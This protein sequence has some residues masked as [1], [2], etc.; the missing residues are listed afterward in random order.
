MDKTKKLMNKLKKT[1]CTNEFALDGLFV[2]G[3]LMLIATNF[4]VNAVFGLYSL[5]VFLIALSIY[6]SNTKLK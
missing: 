1:I 2:V 6:L 5:S 4:I 3:I